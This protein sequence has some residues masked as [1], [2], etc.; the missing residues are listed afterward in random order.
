MGSFHLSQLAVG[1][2]RRPD[3]PCAIGLADTTRHS[4]GRNSPNISR[5]DLPRG[6]L[7]HQRVDL[8][9]RLCCFIGCAPFCA[10]A[11]L[12]LEERIHKCRRVVTTLWLVRSTAMRWRDAGR[13]ARR[14]RMN[15]DGAFIK[16]DFASRLVA[17]ATIPATG[18]AN[19]ASARLGTA[20]VRGQHPSWKAGASE[21]DCRQSVVSPLHQVNDQAPSLDQAFIRF[22]R[23]NRPRSPYRP[24][25]GSNAIAVHGSG[26][27][28]SGASPDR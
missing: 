24:H 10:D 20:P 16:R 28:E 17:S 13:N 3:G 19:S 27:C 23:N 7:R 11:L 18:T 21:V 8:Q 15:G 2:A 25:G 22:V 26:C 5:E 4:S 12:S 9:V 6:L 1:C 14:E